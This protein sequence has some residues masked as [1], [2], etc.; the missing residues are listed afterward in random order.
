[1]RHAERIHAGIFIQ[2][3][4]N[5]LIENVNLYHATG[6]GILAQF[7]QDLTFNQYR[8]IPN[9]AK[10]RYFGG[11]DDGIQVSNCKGKI[12]INDC[13]FAGLMDDPINVHGTSVQVIEILSEKQLKCRF[14][15]HQ[16]KGPT[17]GHAGDK[18]SFNENSAKNS[19]GKYPR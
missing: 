10:N 3:S 12:T 15:H 4:K 18:I 11:G 2:D 7:S 19:N 16:S 1:M 14:M 9:K 17:W 6:L 8:A 5:I 13:E